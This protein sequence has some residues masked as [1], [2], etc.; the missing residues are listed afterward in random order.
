[1]ASLS[2]LCVTKVEPY[3]YPFL[4]RLAFLADVC[5]AELVLMLDGPDAERRLQ[6][7][8]S[9]LYR[10][11]CEV[12]TSKGF[13]ESVLDQA[14]AACS[15]DYILRLDDDEQVSPAMIEW[16]QRQMYFAAD[17]WKFPRMHMWHGGYIVNPPLWPD[18]QTRLSVKSKSG[19]R[20]TI[21]AGSPFGG[22][23]LAPVAIEHYKFLVKSYD[24]RKA[25]AELYDRV[26]PG[27]GTG[28]MLPFSLPEDALTIEVAPV[29]DGSFA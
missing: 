9:V 27:Y 29:H 21:H 20:H 28:G 13:I 6:K 19:G 16:L 17:H 26:H 7:R 25:I 22:G 15:G 14:V 23:E 10:A 8:P 2:V 11:W 18:H 1:M 24:E 3:S 5:G 12:T 4:E